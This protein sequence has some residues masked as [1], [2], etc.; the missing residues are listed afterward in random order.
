MKIGYCTWGMPTVPADVFIPFL[1]RLGYDGVEL[2]VIPGYTTELSVLDATERR[3][4]ATMLKDHQLELPAIDRCGRSGS[5]LGSERP[6]SCGRYHGRRNVDG[7]G[8]A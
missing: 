6:S 3:R 8:R 7:L 4:I 2:T 1:A 5:G